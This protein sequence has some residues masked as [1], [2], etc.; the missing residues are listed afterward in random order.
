MIKHQKELKTEIFNTYYPS[1]STIRIETV[2]TEQINLTSSTQKQYAYNKSNAHYQ[3]QCSEVFRNMQIENQ[4][5]KNIKH[6]NDNKKRESIYKVLLRK[7]EWHHYSIPE[8]P[9]PR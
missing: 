2:G 1:K 7:P 9:Q 4:E 6:E 8:W 5:C 3:K